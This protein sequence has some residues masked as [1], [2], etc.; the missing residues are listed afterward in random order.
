MSLN[1]LSY[2]CPSDGFPSRRPLRALVR[3]RALC[4][5]LV[6]LSLLGC[7]SDNPN[8]PVDLVPLTPGAGG[9]EQAAP[10]PTGTGTTPPAA[11]GGPGSEIGM[12]LPVAPTGAPMTTPAA[13]AGGSAAAIPSAPIWVG[14]WSTGPQL[15]EPANNPPAPGLSNN[16]LRQKMF[17]T[18]SGNRVRVLFSNEFGNGPVTFQAVHIASAGNAAAIDAAT[19]RALLFAGN[20]SVT[21]PQ[22]MVQYSDPIDFNVT[23]LQ[24][25]A[26]T[27][28]FGDA[29]SNIT[30]HP[31]SRTTSYLV[32]G[33]SVAAA[34]L[35][36]PAVTDHW[37]YVTG[38]DVETTAPAA[39]IVTLGDSITDGRGSTTNQN[40]RWPDALAR[41][42]QADPATSHIAVL[43]QGIGGGAVVSGG[44]GPTAI[45]RFQ[46]DVLEQRGVKWV[47]VLEGVND[48]G[49]ATDVGVADRL[50]SAYEGFIDQAHARGLKIFGVPILP[51]AG[52]A[53]YDTAV[54][55]Q[56]RTQVNDWI[57]SSGRFDA[58]IDLDAAVRDPSNQ[59]A[60]QQAF[61]TGDALHLN[62]AGYQ[63]MAAAIDLTLFQ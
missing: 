31:G 2:C 46:R 16:T 9:S 48:I 52:N 62:P 58:V 43:N 33:D 50:I 61:D 37:Y 15:T 17:T 38:I 5:S 40:D 6:A 54:R 36:E 34:D 39:S 26:I 20:P 3:S 23:A 13:G 11:A 30:G 29:P 28:R 12:D 60:L 25:T 32:A 21:I 7:S 47:I 42:L 44:L 4:I 27:I 51:F 59:N 10:G 19:D 45:A 18:L 57:R 55:Q 41:R 63:A 53:G 1:C 8:N 14:T 56:A 24:S 22:G 49:G 35:N